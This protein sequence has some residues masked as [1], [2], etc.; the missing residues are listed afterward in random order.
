MMQHGTVLDP[1]SR[2]ELWVEVEL[3]RG[4]CAASMIRAVVCVQD[5]SRTGC[6][7]VHQG[8]DEGNKRFA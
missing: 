8:A 7:Q 3:D 4:Q 5:G 2:M 1:K 6:V